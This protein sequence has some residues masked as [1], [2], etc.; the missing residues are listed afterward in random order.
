MPNDFLFEPPGL[1]SF[2][3][4]RDYAMRQIAERVDMSQV[5]IPDHVIV[6]DDGSLSVEGLAIKKND[7]L[8]KWKVRLSISIE[9]EG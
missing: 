5:L 7:D 6:E 8:V 2:E 9:G 4:F 1:A 3:S